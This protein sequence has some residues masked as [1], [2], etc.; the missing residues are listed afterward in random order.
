[1][2]PFRAVASARYV[3]DR[4]MI[5]TRIEGCREL[6][7]DLSVGSLEI[8]KRDSGKSGSHRFLRAP[9]RRTLHQFKVDPVGP[10]MPS[11]R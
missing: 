7:V 9:F 6:H 8:V 3:A 11:P 2:V 10:V 4:T 1:M 5:G